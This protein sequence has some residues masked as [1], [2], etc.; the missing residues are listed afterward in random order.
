I[1]YFQADTGTINQLVHLWKFDDDA[2][3]R[4]PWSSVFGNKDFVVALSANVRRAEH[5][6]PRGLR[7]EVPSA[8]RDSGGQ[9]AD[10]GPVGTASLSFSGRSQASPDR[11]AV[12][13][14]RPD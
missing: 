5:R 9:A 14:G 11:A 12:S 3:R 2:D 13:R 6:L 10:R 1:G 8:D 7:R 4:A